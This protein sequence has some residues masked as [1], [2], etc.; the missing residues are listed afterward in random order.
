MWSASPFP[1]FHPRRGCRAINATVRARRVRTAARPLLPAQRPCLGFSPFCIIARRSRV[2]GPRGSHGSSAAGAAASAEQ[3]QRSTKQTRSHVPRPRRPVP[4][5]D[6]ARRPRPAWKPQRPHSELRH[7]LH[8]TRTR[9]PE[10]TPLTCARRC[11]TQAWNG[12]RMAW[13][14]DGGAPAAAWEYD[15]EYDLGRAMPVSL[16]FRVR[17]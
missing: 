15:L 10:T 6:S 2:R 8:T 1:A 14:Y 16:L 11:K 4:R 5:T 12:R 7:A 9:P 17:R 3:L 13:E